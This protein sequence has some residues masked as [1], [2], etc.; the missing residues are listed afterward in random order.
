MDILSK[1][2]VNTVKI[3]NI[4]TKNNIF[5]APM[6]GVTDM[7]FRVICARHGAGLVCSEMV[8][9]KGI[10]YGNSNTKDMLSV[11]ESEHPAA[12]QLF[13]SE[14]DIMAEAVSMLIDSAKVKFD[15]IDINM[16][17]PAPKIVKNGEG[18][19]LMMKPELAGEII[20]SVVSASNI[21]KI[22]VT[23]KIRKGFNSN[24]VNAVKVAEIAEYNGAAAITVH[25]RTREQHYSGDAD[26]KIIA[27]VKKAVSIPVIGNGDVKSAKD[28]ERMFEE[29]GCDAIMVGR[30]ALGNPWIFEQI[31]GYLENGE[32][33]PPPSYS[34]K[35][36][37]FLQHAKME[38]EY[39]GETVALMEMRKHLCWYVK[40]MKGA[41]E[42]RINVMRTESFAEMESIMENL[43]SM[44]TASIACTPKG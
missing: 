22:P 39:K 2:L 3:G 38:A 8:S 7:P 4:E 17:C 32:E 9:A 19:A 24:W 40:G 41:A 31:T 15:I 30:A 23:V 10:I 34:E 27:S 16:G 14:P 21:S 11:S 18:S 43:L 44:N 29:T 1:D 12:I 25:G 33:I 6:A 35:I 28:A 42:A 37:L 20:K 5:L 36:S 13:G 26:W